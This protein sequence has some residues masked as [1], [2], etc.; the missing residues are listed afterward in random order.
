M[1]IL[2][3]GIVSISSIIPRDAFDFGTNAL[4]QAGYRV[5]VAPNV[6]GPA[7]APAAGRARLRR[8]QQAEQAVAPRLLRRV[9]EKH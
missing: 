8:A 2:T 5:K 6:V 3:I 9:A 7:V 4:V 1:N